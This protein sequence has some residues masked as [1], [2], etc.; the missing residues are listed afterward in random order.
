MVRGEDRARVRRRRSLAR[1]DSRRAGSG[2][3]GYD[4]RE[5]GD[6]PAGAPAAPLP[7]TARV[8]SQPSTASRTR[9]SHSGRPSP[10]DPEAQTP[11][12]RPRYVPHVVD[13]VPAPQPKPVILT[14]D[15]DPEVLE[16]LTRDL[17]GQ[18][19]AGYQVV[20]AASG[21]EAVR[22]LTQLALRERPVALG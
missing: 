17:R 8:G 6:D 11:G 19:G 15:D 9:C 12:H 18:H 22:V 4:D 2:R 7:H 1:L 21:T 3:D 16:S 10:A 13:V 20:P 5:H 14:V